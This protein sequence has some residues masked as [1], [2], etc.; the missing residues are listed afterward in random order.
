M[1]TPE[2]A[3]WYDDPEDDSQLRYFDGI[4]WSDRTVPRQA[5]Q[6]QP[7]PE[8]D[9]APTQPRSAAGTDVYGRPVG[10]PPQPGQQQPWGSPHQQHPGHQQFPGQQHPGQQAGWGGH[11]QAYGWNQQPAQPTTQDGQPLASYGSRAGAYLLD[12]LI[13]GILNLILTGWAWWLWIA[14]YWNFVWDAAMANEQDRVNSLTPEEVVGF[15]EWKYLFIAMGLSLLLQLAYHVGFLV[16]RGATPGKMMVG[17]SVRRAD[18]PG[19]PGAGTAFMRYLLPLCVGVLSLV[20]L[21]GY[22]I[23]IATVADLLWPAFDDR[24]QALHDKIAGTQVVKGKQYR[25]TP[26]EDQGHRIY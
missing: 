23:W 6:R 20:P 12:S 4:V 17:V 15:F 26:A 2:R 21:L 11:Q 3:G 19:R 18:R 16:A 13:V 25:R 14:D 8:A 7:A 10:G 22:V 5:P 24:K 9:L 1:S